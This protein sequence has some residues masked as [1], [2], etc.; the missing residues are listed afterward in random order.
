MGGDTKHFLHGDDRGQPV[1]QPLDLCRKALEAVDHGV[2]IAKARG[3][4]PIVYVNP[5][6]EQLTG[7]TADVILNRSWRVLHGDEPDQDDLIELKNVLSAG[8]SCKVVLRHYRRDGSRFMNHLSLSPVRDEKGDVSHFIAVMEDATERFQWQ[9]QRVAEAEFQRDMLVREVHHRIK[10][11]LQGVSG[12]LARH[13]YARPELG[14]TLK[15][16]GAQVNAIAT[17]HGLQG[18][19]M[20][21]ELEARELVEAIARVAG[22]ANDVPIEVH[23][24][25]GPD[26]VSPVRVNSDEGV[27]VALIINELILNAQ[28]HGTGGEG[29]GV[30]VTVRWDGAETVIE[31]ENCGELPAG[32]DLQ[33]GRGLGTGLELARSMLP[34]KPSTL[35]ISQR[36][37]RVVAALRLSAAT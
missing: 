23:L 24:E 7:Y 9:E 19:V 25:P 35:A 6:F 37:G 21:S 3:D 20:R 5:A 10:N 4:L 2:M 34:P 15:E 17:V 36:P 28:K 18:R 27:A 31:V 26:G 22:A 12:L 32:F 33:Q 1:P 8:E 14:D 29:C 13:A 11:S 16:A 30:T